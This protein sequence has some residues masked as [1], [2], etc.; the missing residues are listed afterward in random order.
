MNK[1]IKR[2]FREYLIYAGVFSVFI[3]L[4]MLT[5]PLYMLQLFDRVLSSM[6]KE[7]LFMLTLAA[8]FAIVISWALDYLRSRLMMSGGVV[9]EER[10]GHRVLSG[11]IKHTARLEGKDHAQGLRDVSLLR[12]FLTGQGL[13][14]L[15]DAPWVVFYIIII[16]LFHPLMGAVA[17][18][19]ALLLFAIAYLN[20]KLTSPPLHE[21]NMA[22][23]RSSRFIDS[24]LRN[25]EV[26]SAMGMQPGVE[27]RWQSMNAEVI[28]AQNTAAQRSTLFLSATK[29]LR[30]LIQIVMMATG[31][32]LVIEQH[33]TPGVMMAG[34][35]ILAR[36][37]APVESA[38]G[39]WKQFVDARESYESLDKL[40]G[41]ISFDSGL[42][43]PAPAGELK[44][45]RVVFAPPGTNRPVI[46]GISFNLEEGESLG[47]IGPSAAG[48]STL[49]RL[50]A[51]IWKPASGAV[52]L[53]GADIG[54]WSRNEVGQYIGYLPQDV[55]LFSGT[56]GENIARLQEH[57]S[58]SE[59]V[60]AA[61]QLAGVHEM[62]LR[63]PEGY[64]TEIGEGGAV[65]S[66][67]QR[68][69]IA[70]ARAVFGMPSLVI[71]DEPNANLDAEGEEGLSKA[72]QRLKA[73]K[74]TLIIVTHKP[75][76]L[77]HADKVLVLRDG[78]VE[79]FGPRQEV[80]SR[81][82]RGN[83]AVN[84]KPVAAGGRNG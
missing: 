31:A 10:L 83:A 76:A 32:W 24:A 53:D 23:R 13:F 77:I 37:L 39:S 79:V 58:Q 50:I 71:L 20:E 64:D 80:I 69:R 46:K 34:T 44:V 25:A 70:L 48:K 18:V 35:L 5:L 56:V 42:P 16:Y 73:N 11:V 84:V 2:Y 51:G 1:F 62:I 22:A 82:T 43:L 40:L 72:I 9:L 61:A 63:L 49:L 27:R 7:T 36:A 14:S 30:M 6:S 57:E 60:V 55:E 21:A 41:T 17:T 45:E 78:A 28:I 65:L 19:S 47:I 52:R 74:V 8:I 15:F 26:I 54:T 12:N 59:A 67:G 33:L 66:G 3:N 81:V 29:S 68:Q 75:S 38:I 4:L